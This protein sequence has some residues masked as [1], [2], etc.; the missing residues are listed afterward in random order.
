MGLSIDVPRVQA[1]LCFPALQPRGR[2]RLLRAE[3]ALEIFPHVWE[4]LR[5]LRPGMLSRSRAW[6]ELRR[7]AEP[8]WRRHGRIEVQN[9]VYEVLGKPVGYAIYRL[10]SGFDHGVSTADLEVI[11]V[12][13]LD[14]EATWALWRYLFSIDLVRNIQAH[15]LPVDHALLQLSP[16]PAL[17]RARLYPQLYVRLVDVPQ[18]LNGRALGSKESLVI[19]VED[20]FCPWNAG[21]FL[22]EQGRAE[23]SQRA[24]ELSLDV[25]ALGQVY[26]GGFSFRELAL[27]G[28]IRCH[29][30]NAIER[31]DAIFV[32]GAAPW[33]PDIF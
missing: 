15:M 11:E 17:L 9:V 16:D 2:F 25:S 12:Q 29:V 18:A 21:N 14:P 10:G 30:A 22:L 24:A 1:Q 31:A 6:W 23:P 4:E 13:A 8:D 26:L 28:K 3:S 19:G 27:A 32:R 20:T 7:V 33:C 5:A